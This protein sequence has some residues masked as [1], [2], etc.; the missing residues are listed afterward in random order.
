MER[1]ERSAM[2]T[3]ASVVKALK[4]SEKRM[5]RSR[6]VMTVLK[7][8]AVFGKKE[9]GVSRKGEGEEGTEGAGDATN[10]FVEEAEVLEARDAEETKKEGYS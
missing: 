3:E 8:G 10:S 1:R 5:Q 6:I 7:R 9:E 2:E 4:T